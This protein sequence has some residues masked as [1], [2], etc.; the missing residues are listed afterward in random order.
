MQEV[1]SD[2]DGA[3]VIQQKSSKLFLLLWFSPKRNGVI[4]VLSTIF[5][6]LRSASFRK[7]YHNILVLKVG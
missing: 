5:L 1:A 6:E 3:E 7:K 4:N 2:M